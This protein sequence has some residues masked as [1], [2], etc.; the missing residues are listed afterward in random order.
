V[1]QVNQIGR[2]EAYFIIHDLNKKYPPCAVPR[3]VTNCTCVDCDE[4]KL[5]GG[6]WL[7]NRYPG[8]PSDEEVIHAKM[9]IVV[10]HCQ[11]SNLWKITMGQELVITTPA[12]HCSNDRT[13]YNATYHI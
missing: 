11:H 6:S 9:H 7:G 8:M 2:L 3:V 1:V 4:D 12:S 13:D 10:S 5:C